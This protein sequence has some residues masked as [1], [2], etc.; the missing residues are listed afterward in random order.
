MVA[1]VLVSSL[2]RYHLR[3]PLA[4]Q[5]EGHCLPNK[6]ACAVR[7][8]LGSLKRLISQWDSL[9]FEELLN[10]RSFPLHDGPV[11]A[12]ELALI[13]HLRSLALGPLSV[14]RCPF[15]HSSCSVAT[16]LSVQRRH[17]T[18]QPRRRRYVLLA[19]TC[20]FIRSH[21]AQIL[22]ILAARNLSQRVNTPSDA[23]SSRLQPQ[24]TMADHTHGLPMTLPTFFG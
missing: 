9:S 18:S 23:Q 3:S 14:R 12:T 21:L 2:A 5:D 7:H 13:E 4:P 15:N 10:Y 22:A 17:G 24:M 11:G 16:P 6:V 19:L 1:M 8:F 20:I